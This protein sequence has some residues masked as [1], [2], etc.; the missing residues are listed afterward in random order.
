MRLLETVDEEGNSRFGDF[1]DGQISIKCKFK[2]NNM[3]LLSPFSYLQKD[4]LWQK[5]DN[6]RFDSQINSY[7]QLIDKNPYVFEMANLDLIY[8]L[9]AY[10][11]LSDSD[12]LRKEELIVNSEKLSCW[13]M[14][15]NNSEQ[16][17]DMY[18]LNYCQVLKREDKLF[19]EHYVRLRQ[20]LLNES[21]N[22]SIKVGASLLLGDKKEFETCFSKCSKEE[23]TNLK[24]FPIWHFHKD[25]E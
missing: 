11:K 14:D 21:S 13:L 12:S 16:L 2:D 17:D 22:S 23:V 3:Y 4:N 25:L 5:C 18:F 8:M 7:K 1:F 20:I 10:D 19:E 9:E 6:I 24:R 15:K